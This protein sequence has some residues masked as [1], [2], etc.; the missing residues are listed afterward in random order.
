MCFSYVLTS[1]IFHASLLPSSLYSIAQ[2][3]LCFFMSRLW[4]S[5]SL[6]IY[7]SLPTYCSHCITFLLLTVFKYLSPLFNDPFPPAF[8][9]LSRAILWQGIGAGLLP[10]WQWYG[11]RGGQGLGRAQSIRLV[12]TTKQQSRSTAWLFTIT[13]ELPCLCGKLSLWWSS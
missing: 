13:C 4:G 12:Q 8:P 11:R 2:S 6:Q 7:L 1:S 10:R 3:T 9:A 5:Y